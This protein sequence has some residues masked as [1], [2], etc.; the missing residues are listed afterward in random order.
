M[1]CE[2]QSG[3]ILCG[4]AELVDPLNILSHNKQLQCTALCEAE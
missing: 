1:A 4:H 3:Y 2:T